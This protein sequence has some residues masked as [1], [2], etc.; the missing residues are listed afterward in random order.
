[1]ARFWN[2]NLEFGGTVQKAFGIRSWCFALENDQRSEVQLQ[3]RSSACE[4]KSKMGKEKIIS[5]S[6]SNGIWRNQIDRHGTTRIVDRYRKFQRTS[7]TW[8]IPASSN[9]YSRDWVICLLIILEVGEPSW[10]DSRLSHILN[11]TTRV[12]IRSPVTMINFQWWW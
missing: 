6:W 11:F 3:N 8:R 5:T 7:Y 12:M 9:C 1:M 2:W 10:W 4:N